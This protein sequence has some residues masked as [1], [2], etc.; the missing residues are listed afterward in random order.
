MQRRTFILQSLC[1]LPALSALPSLGHSLNSKKPFVIR[2]DQSRFGI[3]TP[4]RGIIPNNL[5]ISSKDTD[6][7]YSCFDYVGT[8]RVPGPN[9][10]VHLFQDELFYA[11]DGAFV[12]QIGN[13]KVKIEKGDA[14]YSPRNIQHTWTQLSPTGRLVYF[15]SP[16]HKME[17]FFVYL[18]KL[19]SPPTKE[20]GKKIDN[21][22][23][24][25]QR[26]NAL[27]PEDQHVFSQSLSQGYIVKAGESRFQEHLN[28]K[29]QSPVNLLLS[30]KDSDKAMSIFD[31]TGNTKG[32][33]P[34]H[35]HHHQD[36]VFFITEGKYLFEVGGQRFTLTEGDT[37]F[38]PKK[39]PH[40]WNQ[41][42]EKGKLLFFFQPAGKMEEFFALYNAQTSPPLPDAGNK[43]FADHDMTV[44]GPPIEP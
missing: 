26:G 13:E 17:E 35:V 12:F 22:F 37:I 27:N 20:E 7:T 25:L 4:F 15:V 11:V 41:L 1:A 14:V 23:G 28:H 40:T 36:E 10:H 6:G 16:A 39:I 8:Q 38:L 43:M 18:S 42:S 34:M 32:G 31:Y 5:K 44:V 19:K 2:S 21:E 24:I 33:P 30:K 9:L 29:N 3:E